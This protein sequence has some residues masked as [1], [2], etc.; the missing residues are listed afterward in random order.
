MKSNTLR[1]FAPWRPL[2]VLGLLSAAT[3]AV[4]A[5]FSPTAGGTYDYLD[6]ANWSGGTINNTWGSTLTG[7]QTLTFGTDH[8]LSGSLSLSYGGTFNLTFVGSGANR[9]LTLGGTVSTGSS[10]APTRITFGST[11]EGQKLSL[12]L[13]GA[14]RTFS[15]GTNRTVELVNGL[16]GTGGIIKQGLGTL[17]LTGTANSYTGSTSIGTSGQSSGVLEVTK[18]ANGGLASSIGNSSNASGNLVFGGT[19][20][21]TLRYV[22][23]GDSTDRR[24][25]IG[26]VGAIF[27]ASGT[28][29]LNFTNTAAVT[30]ASAGTARTV[31]FKGDHTGDNT[32]AAAFADSGAGKISFAKDGAGTWVLSGANTNT[33]DTTVTQ[34]V[35]ALGA[36]DRLS[37][38]SGLVMNGGTFATRGFNETLGLLTLSASSIIDLGAGASALV[39]ADS[40]G[41]AWT[42]SI[43][44]S[45]TNF[46]PGVDSIRIGSTAGGLTGDQ[47][48][49]IT[50]NGFAAAIDANGFL[51][52]SSVPEPS[53]YALLAGAGG[54]LLA[55]SRR[56][57]A[58]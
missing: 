2:A 45:F 51:S 16:S 18:L 8:T 49:Q 20:T 3:P 39:F 47:L 10:S 58:A 21:G 46:T 57:R 41:V 56:R 13:N 38:T 14:T 26:G 34:G 35:L 7:D 31:T 52:I 32:M 33:G 17:V 12:D 54:L 22:G 6:T 36:A 43:G 53:T 28:G 23:A 27:D 24:F 48:A 1:S 9:T 44:L 37:D 40:S 15:T 55:V 50:L 11:T 42:A 30:Y 5:N 19:T 29:A 4:F 25:L